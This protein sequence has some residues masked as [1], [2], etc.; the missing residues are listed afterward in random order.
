MLRTLSLFCIVLFAAC[1]SAEEIPD[2]TPKSRTQFA[3]FTETDI[4]PETSL[5]YTAADS[6][7]DEKVRKYKVRL[8]EGKNKKGGYTKVK[9][10]NTL[11]LI[12]MN[13]QNAK[14][15][16]WD[17]SILKSKINYLKNN[18]VG[19]RLEL[20]IIRS[21]TDS[22]NLKNFTVSIKDDKNNELF[23]KELPFSVALPSRI[24]KHVW[25]SEKIDVP[26]KIRPPFFVYVHDK[27]AERSF[28]FS[29]AGK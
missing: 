21:N 12:K 9:Y 17:E 29:V 20:I 13:K 8:V 11:Q 14:S 26:Q 6:L 4:P 28:K 22:A 3:S 25:N 18:N 19:G 27:A 16:H 2:A 10:M 23:T 1:N 7:A 5:K 15:Q 24:N